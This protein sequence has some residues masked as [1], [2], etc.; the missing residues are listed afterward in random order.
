MGHI[1][2]TGFYMIH[3]WIAIENLVATTISDTRIDLSWDILKAGMTGIVIEQSTDGVNYTEIDFLGGTEDT[4]SVTGLTTNTHYWY[5]VRGVKA[6]TYSEYSNVDDDWT[7]MKLVFTKQ[8]DGTGRTSLGALKASG[9]SITMT[10][11]GDAKF[12]NNSTGAT[13]E[14]SSWTILTTITNLHIQ[15]N[16][17]TSNVLIFHKNNF[18]E[19]GY[20]VGGALYGGIT[21]NSINVPAVTFTYSSLARSLLK[22]GIS[23]SNQSSSLVTGSTAD[24]PPNLENIAFL[25]GFTLTGN[26]SD[27]PDS[28]LYIYFGTGNSI[29]GSIAG[30]PSSLTYLR[31]TG[32]NTLSGDI[33]LLPA[34]LTSFTVLGNNTLSGD[35]ED[36]PQ[37]NLTLFYVTGSNTIH[38]AIVDIDYSSSVL[39]SFRC[40]GNNTISGAPSDVSDSLTIFEI[41]GNSNT[42]SGD[43]AGFSSNLTSITVTGNS[44]S[45]SGTVADLSEGLTYVYFTGPNTVSGNIADLP[46]TLTFINISGSNTLTGDISGFSSNMRTIWIYGNNTISGD[47]AG[48]PD[49]IILITITGVNTIEGNISG[50]PTSAS[51]IYITGSN[52]L[53]GSVT[54]FSSTM[55]TV[56]IDGNNTISGAISD[57]PSTITSIT[58]QGLNTISGNLAD[59]SNAIITFVLEG[60]NTINAYTSGKTWSN[61][62]LYSFT[63]KPVAGG[64]LDATEID[65]LFIDLNTSWTTTRNQSIDM[66]GT[67]AAPTAASLSARNSLISKGRTIYV[68]T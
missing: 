41:G 53:T 36:I 48:M 19:L 29:T 34:T 60:N 16:S 39:T 43:I 58:I 20:G 62:F 65:N 51:Y 10:C 46:S 1:Q 42:F 12:Y 61:G 28:L 6:S 66:R 22:F 30:L 37:G 7:A 45:L 13:G 59:I 33:S 31:I 63:C 56:Q 26:V 8:G 2:A 9:F 27:L 47:I 4:H 17:G 64:G 57:I 15:V 32:S 67:N 18:I 55:R 11:D 68:N 40:V 21:Q 50:I 54:G 52:T 23:L 14:S 44:S 38:G 3:Q 5:R 35:I 24:F 49:T 25:S